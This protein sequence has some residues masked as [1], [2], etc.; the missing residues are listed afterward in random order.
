MPLHCAGRGMRRSY[1]TVPGFRYGRT[2]LVQ[3]A[4]RI[5]RA[6]DH[7]TNPDHLEGDARNTVE[8]LLDRQNTMLAGHPFDAD[9]TFMHTV[10][11][12]LDITI[13][14]VI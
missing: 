6:V 1:R 7:G 11:M 9:F 10:S 5:R 12:L 3:H 4:L 8:C 13:V 14:W 2:H